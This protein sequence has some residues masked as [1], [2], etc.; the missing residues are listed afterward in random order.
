M[1]K[2][3]SKE[4]YQRVRMG[5]TMCEGIEMKCGV[6]QGSVFGPWLFNIFINDLFY[7]IEYGSMYNFNDD[8]KV[9]HIDEDVDQ[10]VRKGEREVRI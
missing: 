1:L 6:P 10:V 7:V 4:R 8:N 9:S 5:N 2:S 3:Y